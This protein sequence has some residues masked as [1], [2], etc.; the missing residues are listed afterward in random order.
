M[1]RYRARIGSRRAIGPSGREKAGNAGAAPRGTRKDSGLILLRLKA[2]L[3]AA[4]A[5]LAIGVIL[6]TPTFA[7]PAQRPAQEAA[8]ESAEEASEAGEDARLSTI[9][10]RWAHPIKYL[11][12]LLAHI[13]ESIKYTQTLPHTTVR[14]Q[15]HLPKKRQHVKELRARIQELWVRAEQAR[16]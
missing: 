11:K 5:A 16:N 12:N 15:V 8:A 4:L 6:P 9:P 3:V 13:R 14:W 10:A 1:E 7:V 2:A